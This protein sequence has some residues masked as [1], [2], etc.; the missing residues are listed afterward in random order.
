MDE[1]QQGLFKVNLPNETTNFAKRG[2]ESVL[3]PAMPDGSGKDSALDFDEYNCLGASSSK[4]RAE[5]E[6]S[7]E[8]QQK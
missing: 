2:K 8:Q 6:S 1:P 4:G 3:T 5:N 7:L